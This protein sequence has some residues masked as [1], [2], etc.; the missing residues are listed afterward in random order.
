MLLQCLGALSFRGERVHIVLE[1]LGLLGS[2]PLVVRKDLTSGCEYLA[3]RRLE[4]RAHARDAL[5]IR[6]GFSLGFSLGS[7]LGLDD[8]HALQLCQLGLLLVELCLVLVL[9]LIVLE[10]IGT[11]LLLPQGNVLAAL[12]DRRQL[13][14]GA[15]A[16]CHALTLGHIGDQHVQVIHRLL[17]VEIELLCKLV[18]DLVNVAHLDYLAAV[19]MT[20]LVPN[21]SV[22]GI[23]FRG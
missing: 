8:L 5:G 4:R 3:E 16:G 1:L 12:L 22:F 14:L 9:G 2:L 10:L 6:L 7:G 15:G 19:T 18:Y 20:S 17:N 13:G 11:L 21:K 23:R